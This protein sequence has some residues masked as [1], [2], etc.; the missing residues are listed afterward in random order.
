M[1]NTV[2]VMCHGPEGT[3][4]GPAAA[5]LNPKPRN[6]TDAAWQASVT[7]EQLKE[8]IL[9]GGAGV[10]KSPVMPGQPQ[11]ADHPEVLDELVQIIR[12]FGKQP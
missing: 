7:D 4:N 1:F 5:T 11:L 12:R 10:G 8:T 9:K 2:C 3:G 6:Y